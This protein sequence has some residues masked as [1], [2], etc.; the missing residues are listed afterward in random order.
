MRKLLFTTLF[1]FVSGAIINS[2]DADI[3]CTQACA[4]AMATCQLPCFATQ[5][6]C[7]AA[8]SLGGIKCR[9]R[10]NVTYRVCIKPCLAESRSCTTACARK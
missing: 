8:C 1:L 6:K 10:C 9:H 5:R 3:K 7:R 4:T 2:A